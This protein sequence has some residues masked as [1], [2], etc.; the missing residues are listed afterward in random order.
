MLDFSGQTGL[1]AAI[2]V[3]IAIRLILVGMSCIGIMVGLKAEL[4]KILKML[5]RDIDKVKTIRDMVSN[6]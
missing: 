3:M 1:V 4:A 6:V 5:G 2:V